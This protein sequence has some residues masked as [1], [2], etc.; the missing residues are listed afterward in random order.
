MKAK[1]WLSMVVIALL[2]MNL[3][4]CKKASDEE[5]VEIKS[6]AEYKTE[7]DKEIT[8]ENMETELDKIEAEIKA[9]V[10]N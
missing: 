3:V 10:E 1:L 9:E 4:G 7:A 6:Q 5:V 8:G 2:L